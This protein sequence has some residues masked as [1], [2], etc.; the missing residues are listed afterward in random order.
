[1]MCVHVCECEWVGDKSDERQWR[2]EERVR[3]NKTDN[4]NGQQS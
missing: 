3:D 1:M 4:K 2:R